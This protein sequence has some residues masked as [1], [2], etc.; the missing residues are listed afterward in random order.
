MCVSSMLQRLLAFVFLCFTGALWAQEGPG[1]KF[2]PPRQQRFAVII[3]INYEGPQGGAAAGSG[4]RGPDKLKNAENDANDVC[5][6]LISNYGYREDEVELLIGEVATHDRINE[7]LTALENNEWKN[8]PDSISSSDSVLFYFSG[9]GLQVGEPKKLTLLPANAHLSGGVPDHRKVDIDDL[10]DSLTRCHAMHK[11]L[12]L[13]CCHAG[14]VFEIKLP[15]ANQN[16]VFVDRPGDDDVTKESP[17]FQAMASSHSIQTA[18]DGGG[19]NSPFTDAL[20]KS[21]KTLPN[22]TGHKPFAVTRLFSRLT[23]LLNAPRQYPQCRWLTEDSGEFHFYPEGT[24]EPDASVDTQLRQML[25]AMVPGINGNWWFE[26]TPWMLPA[27]RTNILTRV[28]LDRDASVGLLNIEDLRRAAESYLHEPPSQ[29]DNGLAKMRRKHLG[30]ILGASKFNNKSVLQAVKKELLDLAASG[31]SARAN[32]QLQAEDL[33]FLA[34]LLHS[35]GDPRVDNKAIEQYYKDTID[36][37]SSDD[38]ARRNEPLLTLCYS[39]LGNFLY[40]DPA[41]SEGALEAF[42]KALK[43]FGPDA[44]EP[45]QMYL[46]C[47]TGQTFVLLGMWGAA[48]RELDQAVKLAEKMGGSVHPLVGWTFGQRA[49]ASMDQWSVKDAK[50]SFQRAKDVL[51]PLTTRDLPDFEAMILQLHYE[52]GLAIAERYA[53]DSAKAADTYF[54]LIQQIN[55]QRREHA[56]KRNKDSNGIESFPEIQG[57]FTERLVNS[58]TRRGDCGLFGDPRDLEQADTDYRLALRECVHIPSREREVRSR[59]ELLQKR[60]LTLALPST[61]EDLPLSRSLLNQADTLAPKYGIASLRERIDSGERV[62]SAMHGLLADAILGMRSFERTDR[63][64]AALS[65]RQLLHVQSRDGLVTQSIARDDLEALLFGAR[66]LVEFDQAAE[67]STDRADLLDDV[68]LLVSLCRV[69]HRDKGDFGL[70]TFL[71]PYYNVAIEAQLSQKGKHVRPSIELIAEAT[72]GKTAI[73]QHLQP[74]I[75]FYNTQRSLILLLDVPGEISEAYTVTNSISRERV[76]KASTDSNRRLPLPQR[77]IHDWEKLPAA[78]REMLEAGLEGKRDDVVRWRDPVNGLG[79]VLQKPVE[80]ASKPPT[81]E[82]PVEYVILEDAAFPF[83]LE[84]LRLAG[85]APQRS[86]PATT[87][88][89]A[90]QSTEANEQPSAD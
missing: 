64:Q 65:L 55:E 78:K 72:S 1:A 27:L 45:V 47:R 3:G 70:L 61:I 9:H 86:E 25:I 62:P 16:A 67:Q 57:R 2:E 82:L 33:H 36:L 89:Q 11:L 29:H 19:R 22:R 42:Q 51:D 54:T 46:R 21:L 60:A 84:E 6:L 28:A 75:C 37:Y 88:K 26:E 5:K 53:G 31:P 52:H 80:V 66:L 14:G 90:A 18:S 69:V 76:L 48:N 34:A 10:F 56:E 87:F 12:V 8:K 68:E 50:K 40:L 39:D 79:K 85:A 30:M 73:E 24:F 49:W 13:D 15:G 41:R 63:I 7:I 44:P 77:F 35:L 32:I 23:M 59:L 83:D 17:A 20:V 81:V 38:Q 43:Q 58:L 71:R 74:R 4:S